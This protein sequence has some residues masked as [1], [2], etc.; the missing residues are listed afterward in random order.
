MVNV[1]TSRDSSSPITALLGLPTQ[2]VLL[3]HHSHQFGFYFIFLMGW[4]CLLFISTFMQYFW[5]FLSRDKKTRL[6]EKMGRWPCT[7]RHLPGSNHCHVNNIESE[8]CCCC[9]LFNCWP[10]ADEEPWAR[11]ASNKQQNFD[12]IS[13]ILL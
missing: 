12:F 6:D 9:Y 2:D 5:Q 13:D 4:N 10:V 8:N 1:T 7:R 3:V 11:K